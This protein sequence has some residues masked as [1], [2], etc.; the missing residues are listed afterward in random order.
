[1]RVRAAEHGH[2]QGAGGDPVGDIAAPAQQELRVLDPADRLAHPAPLAGVVT[3]GGSVGAVGGGH[4]ATSFVGRIR[5]AAPITA[6]V[7][8]W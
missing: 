2:V 6:S 4:E 5:A 7:M 3:D 1:M 8:N